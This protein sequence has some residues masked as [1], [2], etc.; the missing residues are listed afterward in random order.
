MIKKATVLVVDDDESNRDI[1]A[2]Y[3][4]DAGYRVLEAPSGSRALEL[5]ATH[6][7]I[8]IM[9]LDRTMPDLD[10]IA[11]LRRLKSEP[12]T[13]DLPVILQTAAAAS[14]EILEGIREGAFYYLTKPYEKSTM[15][16]IVETACA[17]QRQLREMR[18]AMTG[19]QRVLALLDEARFRFRTLEEVKS[20]AHLVSSC[21]PEPL[22]VIYGLSELMINAVEHGNLGITY[23][24]KT[25]L[26]RDGTWHHEVERR[27]TLPENQHR[28]A[29]LEF[30]AGPR[31]LSIV[32]RD[33]GHGFDWREYLELRPN[34]AS[35]LHG[36][37]VAMARALSF[38]SITYPGN[39]NMVVCTVPSGERSAPTTGDLAV[40]EPRQVCG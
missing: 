9:V 37:G 17:D 5:L 7:E 31:D 23:A 6:P 24:G 11:V 32:I 3:L 26:L 16:A 13:R 19:Q 18:R 8:D 29:T 21:C 28:Y 1:L 25:A 10:G 22:Q 12:Q 20:L 30:H 27:L 2:E 40:V 38:S 35:D 39:G 34:R 15:L 14:H 4:E 33:Q 36:R